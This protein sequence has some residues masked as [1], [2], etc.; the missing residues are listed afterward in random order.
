[1]ERKP[2]YKISS[3]L[4]KAKGHTLLDTQVFYDKEYVY[5]VYS[6][7][8]VVGA[9][10]SSELGTPNAQG[11]T[12]TSIFQENKIVQFEKTPTAQVTPNGPIFLD[13]YTA[14]VNALGIK[15]N[16]IL[17]P[18]LVR[19]PYYNTLSLLNDA[20]TPDDQKK[21][22]ILD[23]PPLAPDISF[24]PYKDVD[25]KVLVLLNVNYGERRLFPIRVF[26]KI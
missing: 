6:I 12:P 10:Y 9:E 22:V 13:T 24:Y 7:S 2:H 25:D 15:S 26:L 14:D 23:K 17:K 3:S 4:F 19:A 21:T 18:I 16:V 5:E 8:L 11:G 20:E 1:M